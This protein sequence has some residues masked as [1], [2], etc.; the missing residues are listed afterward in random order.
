MTVET[1]ALRMSLDNRICNGRVMW[2]H[3]ESMSIPT[4]P[5]SPAPVSMLAGKGE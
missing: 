5:F 4:P 2:L 3:Y 1:M